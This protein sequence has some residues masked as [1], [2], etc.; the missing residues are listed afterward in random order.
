M[1]AECAQMRGMQQTIQELTRALLQDAQG[2]G[3]KHGA[4]ELHHNFRCLNPP[5][6]SD[7]TDLDEAEHWLKETK[8]IFRVMQCAYI[9]QLAPLDIQTY[10]EMVKKAQLLED[11]TDFTHR[12]KGKFV[13]KEL[14]PGLTTAKPS[15]GKKHPFSITEGP[16]QEKKPRVFVPTTPTKSNCKHC[17]KPGHTTDECWRKVG[18]RLRCGSREHRILECPMMKEHERLGNQLIKGQ[19]GL[20]R[21]KIHV[22]TEGV[23]AP[24]HLALMGLLQGL[25]DEI[26][27][28]PKR[29][30]QSKSSGEAHFEA[31]TSALTMGFSRI[32]N[33][34]CSTSM[35]QDQATFGTDAEKCFSTPPSLTSVPAYGNASVSVMI[36]EH[37]FIAPDPVSAV[38]TTALISLRSLIMNIKCRDDRQPGMYDQSPFRRLD[39]APKKQTAYERKKGKKAMS[40]LH[41]FY[42]EWT[43]KSEASER[44]TTLVEAFL[45][46]EGY[47]DHKCIFFN[48]EYMHTLPL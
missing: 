40:K 19:Q 25:G 15:I 10:A 4:G 47:A 13:K 16:S 3:G 30:Q 14:T 21:K 18:A 42:K 48:M 27:L 43:C 44:Q 7:T 29:L 37:G 23:D 39:K 33:L 6:F 35:A 11:A 45:A 17:D 31:L 38:P 20:A 28:L 41:K 8:R 36:V 12:I 2:G 24:P 26:R 32:E 5:K 22:Q 34:I 1:T 9:T 46:E